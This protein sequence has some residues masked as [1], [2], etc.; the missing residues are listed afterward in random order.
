ML[1]T[2]FTRRFKCARFSETRVV[3]CHSPSANCA[4]NSIG[5]ARPKLA[6]ELR[7]NAVRVV[8][9]C[10]ASASNR[11]PASSPK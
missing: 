1:S 7:S 8:F 10:S 4:A 11:P 3:F 2:P 6:F 9:V 5:F